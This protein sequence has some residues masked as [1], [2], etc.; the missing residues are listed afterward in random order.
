MASGRRIMHLTLYRLSTSAESTVGALYVNGTFAAWTLEDTKRIKKVAGQTR[1]PAGNYQIE[2]RQEGGM[3]EKYRRRFEGMHRG[4]LWLQD[5]PEFEWIYVHTGNK[6]GHTEGCILVGNSLNNN[7]LQDG[8]VGASTSAYR[9]IY[10]EIS[11]A[12]AGGEGASIRVADL[13]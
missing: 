1:I 7:T 11:G 12:I 4:M 8:F 6:R 10:P 3:H 13:G 5:V 9:R 2:L